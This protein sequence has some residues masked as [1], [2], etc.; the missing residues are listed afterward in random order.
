MAGYHN[1]SMSNNAISAY[2]MGER[3]LSKWSKTD[4]INKINSVR[5][6]YDSVNFAHSRFKKISVKVM[7]D[8]FL[9][10]SSWH[11]TSSHYNKT[12]FYLVDDG[13][14]QELN[15]EIIAKLERKTQIEK[16]IKSETTQERWECE[17]L[18]WG[19]TRKHPKATEV[20]GTGTIIGN[21]FH[22][23]DGGKKSI[24]ANGFRKLRRI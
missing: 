7:R 4:L 18:I 24:N 21:W 20:I 23:D 1:Y 19:G 16:E 5:S 14:V 17:Y 11:H 8:H 22:L 6:D 3:P 10:Q 13:A 15:G 9:R 12:K 2:D